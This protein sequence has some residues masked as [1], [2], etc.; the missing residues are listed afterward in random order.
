M[1]QWADRETDQPGWVRRIEG[2]WTASPPRPLD[3]STL[4]RMGRDYADNVLYYREGGQ[5]GFE[6]KRGCAA[7]CIYCAD[8]VVKGR[9]VRLR[10]PEAVADELDALA[11]QGVR[12]LHTCDAEFNR[13]PDHALAVC[14]SIIRRSLG[15][16]LRWYAYCA[17]TPF[18]DE[19]AAAMHRAGCLGINFGA[20]SGD[21][22]MLRRLGRDYT[23]ADLRET[24]RR[25]RK[26]G[27]ACIVDLLL[28]GPG[29]TEASVRRSLDFVRSALPDRIGLSVGVRVY[30]STP[31]ARLAARQP[32]AL[33]GP[34]AATP[35]FVAP[36]FYLST[37]LGEGIFSLIRSIVGD[38]RRFFFADPTE[39][40]RN[41]NY[42]AN[43]L[44]VDALRRGYRGAYWDI[45]RRVQEELPPE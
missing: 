39:A 9:T 31:L 32:E 43:Q 44:L 26:Q 35:D 11:H 45:L 12:H 4:P 40:N 13:P 42:N 37:E 24:L 18:P 30:P 25:C 36:T 14:E 41:Y 34:G 7:A 3:L 5:I 38:D 16:R 20:D 28:G 27:M 2:R 15:E 22:G 17:P 1:R 29:E 10:P 8:P 21:D 23:G 33:H 6:T 19:L